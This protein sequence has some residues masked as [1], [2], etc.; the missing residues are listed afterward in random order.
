LPAK[1][2]K[3]ASFLPFCVG[4]SKLHPIF[5]NT[6]PTTQRYKNYDRLQCLKIR[7]NRLF[8]KMLFLMPQPCSSPENDSNAMGGMPRRAKTILKN[9][10]FTEIYDKS[11]HTGSQFEYAQKLGIKVLVSIPV[12]SSHAPDTAY[13]VANFSYDKE[14]DHHI[15]L[16]QEILSTSQTCRSNTTKLQLA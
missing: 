7:L 1:P 15:C 12:V 13:D 4:K 2:Q 16:A 10:E 11:Y 6:P 3:K 5:L 14:A 9:D 8:A